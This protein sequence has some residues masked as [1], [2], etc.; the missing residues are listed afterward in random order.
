MSD[1]HSD[2]VALLRERSVR[3]GSFTLSSGGTT[4]FYVDARVTTLHAVGSALVAD[5]VLE[6]LKP[7]VVAVGGLTLGADPIACAVAAR[8]AGRVHGF[9]IRKEAK[10]HGTGQGVEGRANLEDGA[11]VCIVEDTTT[12]GR[13]LLVAVERARAAGLRVVQCITVVDREEG[14]KEAV[15][16][17]GLELEPLTTRTELLSDDDP[18]T[19]S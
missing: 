14:A 13:S 5:L 17:A 12:T 4:D 1:A 19:L 10:R 9:L 7:G 2:L 8:S 6:R 16:A 11:A 3:R 18:V 15:A